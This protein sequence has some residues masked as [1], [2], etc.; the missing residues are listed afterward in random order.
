MATLYSPFLVICEGR[1]EVNYIKELMQ[2]RERLGIT[3]RII[4]SD[5]HGG[6]CG[7]I[8]RAFDVLKR[9]NNNKTAQIRIWVD[10]DLYMRNQTGADKRCAAAFEKTP[11]DIKSKFRFS[12]HNFERSRLQNFVFRAA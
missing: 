9:R 4:P 8:V 11:P 2:V 5:A 10:D 6:Q 12:S 1:S 3:A 7:D